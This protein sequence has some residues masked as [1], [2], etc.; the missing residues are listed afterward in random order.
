MIQ[1]CYKNGFFHAHPNIFI[2][3]IDVKTNRLAVSVAMKTSSLVDIGGAE[4]V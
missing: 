2:A 3:T 4:K 1:E